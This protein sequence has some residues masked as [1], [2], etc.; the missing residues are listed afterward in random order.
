MAD[1]LEVGDYDLRGP[2]FETVLLGPVTGTII[3]ADR[4]VREGTHREPGWRNGFPNWEMYRCAYA[5]D[6]HASA[7]LRDWCILL[8]IAYG[9][10]GGTRRSSDDMAVVAGRDIH[11]ALLNSRWGAPSDEAAEML[12]VAPKTY[13]RFRANLYRRLKASLTEYWIR[14]QIAM[15]QIA[16][17]ERNADQPTPVVRFNYADVGSPDFAGNGCYVTPPRFLRE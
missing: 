15:R 8:A 17:L 16:L 11:Y 7:K 9:E 6:S 3:D 13:R 10:A 12:G 1:K 14:L 4:L 5:G 2:D